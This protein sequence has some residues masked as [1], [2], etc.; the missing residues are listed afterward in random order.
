MAEPL[1]PKAYIYFPQSYAPNRAPR[2]V[3]IV[4]TWGDSLK[5][6]ERAEELKEGRFAFYPARRCQIFSQALWDACTEWVS[7]RDVVD[8]KFEELMKKGVLHE[9]LDSG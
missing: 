1:T 6:A 9:S 2:V 7:A 5:G 8:K 3:Q 4:D